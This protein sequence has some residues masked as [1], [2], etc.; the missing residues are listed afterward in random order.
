LAQRLVEGHL[1][2]GASTFSPLKVDSG[3]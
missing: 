3:C 1:K 2:V